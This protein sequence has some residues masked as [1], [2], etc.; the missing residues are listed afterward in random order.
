MN[1]EQLLQFAK[2]LRR[3]KATLLKTA[4]DVEADLAD[5]VAEREIELEELAQDEGAAFAY[6]RLDARV[7]QEVEAID[8]ALLRIAN[9]TFG[10]CVDCGKR[11]PYRRLKALPTTPY[12]VDCAARHERTLEVEAEAE[13]GEAPARGSV[14]PDLGLLSDRE[15]EETLRELVREDGRVDMDELR[16]V[17]RHGVVYLSGALPSEAQRD[18]LIKLITDVAGVQDIVDRLEINELLWEREDRDRPQPPPPVEV[19]PE[20]AQ[21]EDLIEAAEEGTEYSPPAE[22]PPDKE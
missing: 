1:S 11:I 4:L 5:I 17:T 9:G 14:P 7:R 13:E 15:L 18:I 2:E 19:R 20:P 3:Q 12:C 8:A 22:P 16:I 10:I 21:T 6:D